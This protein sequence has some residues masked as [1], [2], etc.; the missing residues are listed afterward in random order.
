MMD[1]VLNMEGNEIDIE[2]F[3]PGIFLL[4]EIEAQRLLKKDIAKKLGILPN[5]LSDIFAGKRNI[6]ATLSIK[7]ESILGSSAQYWFGM[8]AQYDLFMA[9]ENQNLV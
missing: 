1:N 7:L 8:Q 6:S 4:E 5:H 3:H 9:K 2:A